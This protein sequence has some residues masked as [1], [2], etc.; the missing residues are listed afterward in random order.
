MLSLTKLTAIGSVQKDYEERLKDNTNDFGGWATEFVSQLKTA[1][2]THPQV[3]EMINM[4]YLKGVADK[5]S[6]G[7]DLIAEF[8][9]A[10]LAIEKLIALNV[11]LENVLAKANPIAETL[12]RMIAAKSK[13]PDRSHEV[14]AGKAKRQ[15]CM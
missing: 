5:K 7:K 2:F 12:A 11:S 3:N 1:Q 10:E 4:L 13:G 14:K 6:V 15:R 9:G 8:G